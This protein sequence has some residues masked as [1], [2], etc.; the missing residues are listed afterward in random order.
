MSTRCR[1]FTLVELLVV[2]G[3][4][5]LL[6]GLLLPALNKARVISRTA[7]CLSNLRTIGFAMAMYE[8]EK[9]GY[10]PYPVTSQGK[11]PGAS[12][13]VSDET[14][15]WFNAIDPYLQRIQT[16]S[17]RKGVA[18]DRTY[19]RIK[20]CIVW[21]DF[22]DLHGAAGTSEGSLG[23]TART[24]KMNAY[25]RHGDYTEPIPA[26]TGSIFAKVTDVRHAENFVLIGDGVSLDFTGDVPNQRDSE[27]FCMGVN[28]HVDTYPAL[29]H[30]GRAN[31]LFVDGHAISLLLAT[32]TFNLSFTPKSPITTWQAEFIVSKGSFNPE[33]T[34][35]EQPNVTRNP[36][37]TVEWSEPGI[38]YRGGS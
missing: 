37:M 28:D 13:T 20:Q 6:V 34:L 7:Y 9:K 36:S 31:I 33:K 29:R 27:D 19:S 23:E 18:A 5:G 26:T 11:P 24:F 2:I 30:N 1:A 25:L 4:I 14:D 38:L 32:T 10:F 12:D 3:I 22:P 16:D 15:V 17:S 35:N 8:D 21:Q